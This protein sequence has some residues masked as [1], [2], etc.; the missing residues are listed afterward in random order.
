MKKK[1]VI[2][3]SGLAGT[4]ICNL[5]TDVCDVTLLELGQKA[6][7]SY[8]HLDHVGKHFG[9][10]KTFCFGQGGTT[11][12]WDNGLIPIDPRDVQSRTFEQVLLGARPY[13][14]RTAALLFFSR[15]GYSNVYESVRTELSRVADS[16][17]AFP[18]GVDCLLYP[19]RHK[20]L[21]V[22]DRVSAFYGVGS[23][24]FVAEKG[25][26]T[27]LRFSHGD[28]IQSV[29]PDT[30]IVCAGSLGTP[31]LASQILAAAGYPS[32]QPGLGLMDHPMGFVGKVK[33]KS[34]F[35]ARIQDMACL[36][37]GDYLCRTALRLKSDCGRY[38]GCAFFRPALTMQNRISI[39]K[40]KSLLGASSG[41]ARVR[42]AFSPNLFHPDILAEIYSH[43]LGVQLRSRIFNLLVL[44]EQKRGLSRVS[45]DG[46]TIKVDWRVTDE[47]LAIYNSML[48]KLKAMLEPV[49]QELVI[50]TPLPADWLWS[51]A[52]HSGTISLGD[53]PEG[54]VDK[55]LKLH[56][57]DNAFVCDASVIQEH[58][59]ANTGL[60]IG[61][62]ALRLADHLS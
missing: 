52:H 21:R 7:I 32:D 46:G 30:V 13:I 17:G 18:S 33:V 8:P 51:A 42:A 4:L 36:D 29:F 55:D 43:L 27:S 47:E 5:L 40:Y 23:I 35:R 61:Q 16:I 25:R 2:I 11:N 3:G 31:R 24:D 34:E 48:G 10:V 19:K 15:L 41:M 22:D 58:S 56:G 62:L 6:G 28:G 38:T 37:K 1:V 50:K 57:C 12:L 45:Y 39:Y 49:A 44:F 26:I 54:L 53:P 60:T 14:D 20:A 9:A 59:Y